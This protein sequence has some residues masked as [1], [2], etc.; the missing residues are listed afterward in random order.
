MFE[1][2]QIM[3]IFKWLI[4]AIT[5]F[6]PFI[7]YFAIRNFGLRYLFSGLLLLYLLKSALSLRNGI[8]RNQI[9]IFA[10]IITLLCFAIIL[11]R[12]SL[13]LYT[14]ALI[15]L[16]LLLSFGSTLFIGPPL[17]ETFARRQVNSLS[18]EEVRYCKNL[19]IVWSFFFVFNGSISVI[20]SAAGNMEHWIIYNGFISY[21]LIGLLF[22]IE[23]TYR[24]Y[25]FRNYGN[26]FIDSFF[27]RIFKPRP[28]QVKD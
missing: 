10:T 1:I 8:K 28:I 23:M 5:V 16:G 21:I 12:A 14:P 17:I 4:P 20:I 2:Q 11:N 26:T 25:R 24:Y 13:A 18:D 9:F 15:N 7:I 6:V 22:S 19:T 27:K 3:K